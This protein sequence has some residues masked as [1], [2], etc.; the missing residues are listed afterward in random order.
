MIISK[1]LSRQK[2]ITHGFF[3]RI[4]GKSRGIYKSLNSAQYPS[5]DWNASKQKQGLKD[6][7]NEAARKNITLNY[8]SHHPQKVFY[9]ARKYSA[10]RTR[11]AYQIL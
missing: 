4:G 5:S 3:N 10:Q 6:L 7:I 1:K 9:E 8:P 2:K 11:E